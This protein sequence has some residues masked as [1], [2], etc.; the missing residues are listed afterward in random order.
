VPDPLTDHDQLASALR[1]VEHEAQAYL[2]GLDD[3]LVRPPVMP[4][5]AIPP[6]PAEGDGSAP[7]L[8]SLIEAARDGATR[9]AGPRFF[10]FVMGGS[11][12]AAL[13]ADWLTST[14]DQVA[15]NWVS[16]PFAAHIEQ[17]SLSWLKEM[18]GLP[19]EWSA[20][21]TTGATTGNLVGLAAARRWW[22]L[23]HGVDVDADG[24]GGLPAVTVF[25]GGYLHASAVKALAI[26]GIGRRHAQVLARDVAGHLD[27]DALEI[28]MRA[29]KN[30]PA[31]LIATAGDVNTG[32]FDPLMEM[33]DLANRYGAWLH[34]D[35]AFGLFAALSPLTRGL[36][37]GIERANSVSV[38]GHK[39]LNV[40]YDTGFAFVRDASLHAG[41]FGT[42]A[43]YLGAEA[44][45]RPVFG[46]LAPEMSRRAR[47]L[48]VW[49]TLRAYG[50]DGYRQMVERH[51]G[52]AQRVARQV[53]E[54]PD[55]ERLAD[56]PLN[57]VCFRFHPPGVPD[58]ALDDLNRRLGQLVLEDGRVFFGTTD[59]AG[60]VAFRPAIV[61][62]RT[63]E[64]DVD[65]I[66]TVTR[67]LGA[68]LSAS[69]VPG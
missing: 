47:A 24:F 40:P 62:W 57:V 2:A 61:N 29:E 31:I 45:S 27:L 5:G 55:L 68:R 35:G 54:A 38:D 19:T 1:L 67:E 64:D 53:D 56:V 51:L 16:S 49:A 4:G 60:K 18:F 7:A 14:L 48:P 63:R 66:V 6:L 22:G 12:P 26:L 65:M 58:E 43:A 23:Q 41:S 32:D 20:V 21:I 28:A 25:A 42:T 15:F 11:T 17:V 44:L 39:W 36:V 10:H 46:N 50:R 59:Y 13:G 52:L 33:A 69:S 37:D 9:S 3:A 34:V 30:R 8:I